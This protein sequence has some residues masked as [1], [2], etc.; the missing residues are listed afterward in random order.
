MSRHSRPTLQP[1]ST[2]SRCHRPPRPAATARPGQMSSSTP[3]AAI[4]AAGNAAVAGGR[5][6]SRQ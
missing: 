4:T 3:A 1:G 5:P 6:C 2:D